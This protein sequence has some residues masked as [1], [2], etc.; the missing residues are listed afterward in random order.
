MKKYLL[1]MFIPFLFSCSPMADQSIENIAVVE[2]YIEAVENLD[3]DA[4]EA[5]L[6]DNYFGYGP[7]YG[8]SIGKAQAVESW[9]YN[10]LNLYE[11]I[12]YKRSRS[13]AVVVDDGYN[14]G[15]WVSNWGELVITYKS[16]E[17][18]SLWANTIYQIKNSKIVKS[19]TFYNEA[20]A[21]EQLG[22]VFVHLDDF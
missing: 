19:Y 7:S 14:Q 20:D 11:S 10:V 16:K 5:L 22:F 17:S 13:F 3:Y 2:Q 6:D 4:M 1:F 18:V 12:D 21:L 8:D 9:K 15:E